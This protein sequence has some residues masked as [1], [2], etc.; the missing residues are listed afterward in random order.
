M[1]L[2]II[3]LATVKCIVLIYCRFCVFFHNYISSAS[4]SRMWFFVSANKTLK[5]EDTSW[6]L[7]VTSF[8]R[9]SDRRLPK[10]YS[11]LH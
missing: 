2:M 1:L 6:S 11:N 4:Y 7:P 3:L 8:N 5:H 9:L 10:K